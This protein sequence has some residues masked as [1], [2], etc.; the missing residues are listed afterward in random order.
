MSA[1]GNADRPTPPQRPLKVGLFLPLAETMVDGATP[2]WADL[3]AMARLAE[4]MGFDSLWF[5]DHLMPEG[6]YGHWDGWS[7]LAGIAA[8]T[9]RITLGTIVS[10]T[11]FRNPALLAKMADTVDEISGGRLVLGLGAGWHEPDFRAFGYPFDHLVSRFA[12]A[13]QII[14]ALLRDG[15]VDFVGDYY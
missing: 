13:I 9:Q 5:S 3:V 15:H 12:E 11:S 6:R 1:V 14:H 7:L 2:R 4:A 8:V 10:C